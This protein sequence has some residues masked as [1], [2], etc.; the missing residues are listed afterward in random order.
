MSQVQVQSQTQEKVFLVWKK[1]T[2]GSFGQHSNVYTFVIDIE[3]KQLVPI[4]QLVAVRHINNDSRKNVHR[5]TYVTQ[6]E[7]RKLAGRVLK[8]VEDCASSRRREVT[9]RYKIVTETGDLADLKYET[10]LR[11]S[12]G[13]FDRVYLPDGRVLI[14]RR[15]EV[16]VQ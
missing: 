5:Y 15:E 2:W 14:V 7:M 11:D 16:E 3:K 1:H 13:W 9:V 4:F 6:S 10:G 12:R 8:I